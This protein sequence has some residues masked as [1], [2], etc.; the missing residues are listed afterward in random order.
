[1][2]S[3]YLK[4]AHKELR[5]LGVLIAVGVI[6]FI[7]DLI[8]PHRNDARFFYIILPLAA[9]LGLLLYWRATPVKTAQAI[10]L[11]SAQKRMQG[12]VGEHEFEIDDDGFTE[13]NPSGISKTRWDHIKLVLRLPDVTYVQTTGITYIVPPHSV[14]EGD[15]DQFVTEAVRRWKGSG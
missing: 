2:A 8:F 7:G 14:L 15:Y 13:R 10:F 5:L 12:H 11:M 9:V 3:D 4:V 6:I 1:V